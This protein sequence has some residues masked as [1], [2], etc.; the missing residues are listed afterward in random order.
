MKKQTLLY[1][2]ILFLSFTAP[3]RAHEEPVATDRQPY[4]QQ[5]MI[6][7]GLYVY[8]IQQELAKVRPDSDELFF[9]S[10]SILLIAEEI[11]R[12]KLSP[13]QHQNLNAMLQV[14]KEL[15]R[16]SLTRPDHA[17]KAAHEL[18][19]QCGSCHSNQIKQ[20]RQK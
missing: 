1:L 7:M 19:S 15:R 10:D 2:L 14:V 13:N 4:I 20:P 5:Q 8:G 11:D 9:L 3:L 17:K 12:T 16:S 18:I 6:L